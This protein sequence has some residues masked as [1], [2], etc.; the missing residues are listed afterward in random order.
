MKAATFVSLLFLVALTPFSSFTLAQQS[1]AFHVSQIA[2]YDKAVP[3]QIMELLVEGIE[4]GAS[5]LMLP[6]EDFKLTVLQ[7]GVSQEAK[8]RTVT[9]TLRS[10]PRPMDDAK[11]PAGPGGRKMRSFQSVNFVVPRGLH[12]G[13][14]ELRLSYRGQSGNSIGLTIVEK[15]LRPVLGSVA[16]MTINASSLP[17]ASNR[18]IGNDLGWRLERGSTAQVSVNPLTDPDDPN[19]A[20]VIRFKQGDVYYDAQTRVTNQ[21]FRVENRSRGVGFFPA[22]DILEVDVPAA[23]TMG[24]ADVEIHLRANGQDSEA[25]TLRATI[26]DSTRSEEAPAANAPRLLM[27]APTRVG[28][29]QS[30]ILSLDYRRTLDPDPTKTIIVI[31]QGNARY[32][33]PVERSSLKFG[34]RDSDAPVVFFVRTT[35]EIIGKAQVR[36]FNQLRGQQTG[37]SEPVAIEILDEPLPPELLGVTE[38]T[39][40]DLAPLRQRYEIQTRAGRP[41]SEFDPQRKYVTIQI[42]GIDF[43]PNFVRVTFEQAGRRFT[44]EPV[45]FSS[46][47]NDT[48]IVRQPKELKAGPVKIT[49]ENRGADTFSVPV[50]K[51]FEICCTP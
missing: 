16:V 5:P 12:P 26:T 43:N 15:P 22:R 34:P 23:L 30:M 35:K 4:G 7:D 1:S 31:E 32:I 3:G 50:S 17:P 6:V 37:M 42:K 24:P 38:S 49:I 48:L 40:S 11:S 41:F 29:G 33:V 25:T 20:V 47:G 36:I 2:P 14:A 44:L 13:E 46:Y 21:Q 19:S 10:D 18:I 9:A 27:V 45:N 51:T 8:I 28:A 39:A